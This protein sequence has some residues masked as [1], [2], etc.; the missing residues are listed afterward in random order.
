MWLRNRPGWEHL[1]E[2]LHVHIAATRATQAQAMVNASM[3]Y[4]KKQAL[5][6]DAVRRAEGHIDELLKPVAFDNLKRRQLIDLAVINGNYRPRLSK[7]KTVM[8]R[9][10]VMRNAFLYLQE[11]VPSRIGD[12]NNSESTASE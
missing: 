6:Q 12:E 1:Y 2:P 9:N 5:L 11:W 4:V 10:E 8:R 3:Y 7:Q